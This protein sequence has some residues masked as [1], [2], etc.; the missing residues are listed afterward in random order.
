MRRATSQTVE[1]I[2]PGL[3]LYTPPMPVISHCSCS[4]ASSK[5]TYAVGA[6][7]GGQAGSSALFFR[8]AAPAGPPRQA[9]VSVVVT[10]VS[11]TDVEID[12]TA[13]EV[14]VDTS[15]TMT[16]L[17]EVTSEKTS[18]ISVT[19]WVVTVKAVWTDITVV[20]VD[21]SIGV[22]VTV[23]RVMDLVV[24]VLVVVN[25]VD[26]VSSVLL[27]VRVSVDV[28][29]IVE[30]VVSGVGNWQITGKERVVQKIGESV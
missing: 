19:V 8:T 29:R 18:S 17:V 15:N 10:W 13:D 5:C 23:T 14:D 27:V 12:D 30:V 20:V 21:V 26:T 9:V 4:T 11:V 25:D 3:E 16:V 24:V 1:M 2:D 28:V 22:V 6:M 7:R